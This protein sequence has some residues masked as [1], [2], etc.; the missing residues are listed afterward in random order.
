MVFCPNP[1]PWLNHN[2][3]LLYFTVKTCLSAFQVCYNE[4]RH[5]YILCDKKP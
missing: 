3:N 5:V 2:G 4:K 1:R